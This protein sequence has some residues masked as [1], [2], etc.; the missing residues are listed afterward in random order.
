MLPADFFDPSND[1]AMENR[2]RVAMDAL[3]DALKELKE[4]SIDIAI[5]DS[6]NSREDRRQRVHNRI[7]ECCSGKVISQF[8][9]SRSRTHRRSHFPFHLGAFNLYHNSFQVIMS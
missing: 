1:K 5:Y 6:T 2:E 3:S 4:G 9:M 8:P 7:L